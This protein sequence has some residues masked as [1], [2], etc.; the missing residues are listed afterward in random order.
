MFAVY[1]PNSLGNLKNA[2]H[3]LRKLTKLKCCVQAEGLGEREETLKSMPVTES[4]KPRI[5]HCY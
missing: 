4:I 5:N 1:R 3:K 2:I